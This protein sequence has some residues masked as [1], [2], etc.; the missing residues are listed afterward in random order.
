MRAI[1]EILR[2]HYA[3]QQSLRAIARN[4]GV[5]Y[6]S[7]QLIVA[8]AGT[9]QLTWPLPED[10]DDAAL[11]ALLFKQPSGDRQPHTPPD[12]AVMDR[13]LRS[14][15]GVTRM[16]LWQEYKAQHPDG[17]Q[18]SQFCTLFRQWKRT[19]DPAMR[20]VHRFG[21]RAFLDFAGVG[22]PYTDPATG[23]VQQAQIF[24]ACLAASAYVFAH[25]FAAQDLRSWVLGT[26]L[27]FE[28]FGGVPL[29][30]V[31][32]NPKAAV[33]E[34]HRYEPV[35]HPTYLEMAQHY[36]VFVEPARPA[37]PRDKASVEKAVQIVERQVLAPLRH[38]RFFSLAEVQHA[39]ATGV[40][41]LNRRPFQ[42]RAGC[43][44]DL[45]ERSERPVLRPLP[46]TRYDFAVWKK[47][48]V[49]IDYHVQVEKA[50]Y[51]VPHTLI[52]QQ[53]DV[54]VGATSVAIFHHGRQVALHV[55]A[56]RAGSV[57]T[58]A[59]HMPSTH[60]Q[61]AEWTPSRILRWAQA[62]G[63]HTA[64]W[65]QATLESRPH[66]EIGFRASL[67]IIRL[68]QRY[69]SQRLEAACSRALAIH[70]T[71]Y[72]SVQSILKAGLD[73]LPLPRDEAQEPACIA[74]HAHLRGADYFAQQV[75]P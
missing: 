49:H 26:C 74:T 10:L 53:V 54:R 8:R 18:Y 52:H 19:Q 56:P 62:I 14:H 31:P 38:R 36:N 7:V 57:M 12:W 30:V 9:R 33:L 2:Q 35:I 73:R 39:V 40:E 61:H 51:S 75:R 43:R 21:H 63:P 71:S 50:L 45:F 59:E 23:A 6:S 13:E 68:G 60:R 55:R 41:A 17:Y 15:K 28:A 37:K 29:A 65:I 67:G 16:L 32:D 58:K 70:A 24:V 46:K 11:E 5:P 44:L 34:A 4:I 3:F 66:P 22:V 47:A 1:R 42:K 25:A 69:G 48:R 72:R 64:Q 20:Q 27:A